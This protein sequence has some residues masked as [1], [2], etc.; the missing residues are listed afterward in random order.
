M[1]RTTSPN[2]PQNCPTPG[3]PRPERRAGLCDPAAPRGG[4][5]LGQSRGHGARRGARRVGG[6]VEVAEEGSRRGRGAVFGNESHS[7]VR[8]F[9]IAMDHLKHSNLP[10]KRLDIEALFNHPNVIIP[11]TSCLGAGHPGRMT[12]V[13]GQHGSSLDRSCLGHRSH[14]ASPSPAVRDW[15]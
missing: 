4:A 9:W 1:P 6:R 8:G 13:G 3:A 15:R 10:P 2:P 5:Q 14:P 7:V 12:L 11:R